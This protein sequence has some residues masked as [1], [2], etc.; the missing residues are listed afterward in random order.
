MENLLCPMGCGWIISPLIDTT[1]GDD[2]T[3]LEDS[4]ITQYSL[5]VEH[6]GDDHGAIIGG[7]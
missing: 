1:G 6:L 5:M 3:T 2:P 7:R 4:F